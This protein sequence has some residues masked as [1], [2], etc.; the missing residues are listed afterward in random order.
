MIFFA[1]SR[2]KICLAILGIGMLMGIGQQTLFA[3]ESSKLDMSIKYVTAPPAP[4]AQTT[5]DAD[6]KSSGCV[7]CHIPKPLQFKPAHYQ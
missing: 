5:E 6:K 4:K 7:S 2:K 1:V 3:N